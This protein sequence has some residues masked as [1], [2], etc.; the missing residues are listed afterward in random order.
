[1]NIFEMFSNGD[2]RV[3]EANM[4]SLLAFFMTPS[5]SHAYS[6]SFL[7]E[8]MQMFQGDLPDEWPWNASKEA[9]KNIRAAITAFETIEVGLEESFYQSTNTGAPRQVD[10]DIIVRFYSEGENLSLV[11]A[12]ENKIRDGAATDT[13]QLANEYEF[14]RSS[15]NAEQNCIPILFV[16]LTPRPLTNSG[17]SVN[18]QWSELE[19]R[20]KGSKLKHPND[21]I[22]NVSWRAS[23]KTP[24]ITTL[25]RR[26]IDLEHH[27]HISP[28]SSYSAFVLRSLISFV[29][30]DSMIVPKLGADNQMTVIEE[31]K[32]WAAWPDESISKRLAQGLCA[33]L[34]T[35]QWFGGLQLA[36]DKR[37]LKL[38]CRFVKSRV[39]VYL[40]NTTSPTSDMQ[41]NVPNRICRIFFKQGATTKS[42]LHV[43]FDR[44]HSS[45]LAETAT[46][47]MNNCVNINEDK[48]NPGAYSVV[49]VLSELNGDEEANLFETCKNWFSTAISHSIAAVIDAS[50]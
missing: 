21:R 48:K 3:S 23:E 18:N 14:L 47:T 30:R 50:Q 8:F 27:G 46:N 45:E 34:Q 9:K 29:E 28:P 42:D 24:S 43:A 20:F 40:D 22:V 26:M 1:M 33:Y 32:F 13:N 5:A 49:F 12:I 36:L 44:G 7:A 37:N 17:T 10:L 31:E 25:A 41:K 39:I 38:K 11:L 16:Y 6:T 19:N 2:G 15:M 4:S 35:E